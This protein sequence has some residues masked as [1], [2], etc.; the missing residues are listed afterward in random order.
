MTINDLIDQFEI[1]GAFRIKV[2]DD[3]VYDC[4][5]QAEGKDFE[6]YDWN[7]KE[8]VLNRKITYMYVV[9]NVLNIEVE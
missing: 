3:T 2:W 8:D 5:T 4:V 6:C 9:D 1:Q 7:S